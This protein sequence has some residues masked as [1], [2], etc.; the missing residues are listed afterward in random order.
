[1]K[2][3]LLFII[4]INCAFASF[5]GKVS[6]KITDSTGAILAYA[7]IQVKDKNIGT[8]ANSE[9]K[10][11]LSL[12]PG[13]YTIICQHV[14]Y[15]KQEKEIDVTEND[16]TLDFQLVQQQLT[17]SEVIIKKGEDPAYEIIRNAIKKRPVYKD[18]IKNF[19]CEVYTKG[20][21]RLRDYPK[22][23][24][25]SKVEFEDGDTSKKRMLYLS[26][27]ISKYSVQKP[28][29]AK[30]EVVASKVSGQSNSFGLS[31][32][33]IISFYENNIRIGNLSPRGFV[34]PIADGALNF[35]RYKYEGAFFEDGRQISHIKVIPKRKY[36]P[37]F[38]GYINIIEDEWR[39]HSLDLKL[40]KE[41]Q[42]EFVDTLNLQQLYIPIQSNAWVIKSQ[43][44]YPAIK[45]FGFDMHGSFV[46]I[47]SAFDLNPTFAKG[48]FDNTILKYTDSSNK[49]ANDYWETTRPIVLQQDEITDYKKKDSI[50]K[51]HKDPRYLDSLDRR[52][53]SISPVELLLT[54]KTFSKEKKRTY[55]NIPS[56]LNTVNF[57]TAEGWNID[58]SPT[59]FKRLDTLVASRNNISITPTIRYGFS[60][61]H[62]N[63]S[64]AVNYVYGKKYYNRFSVSGGKYVFQFN[65][66]NPIRPFDNTISSLFYNKNYMKVYEAW[67]GSVEYSKG[68]DAGFNGTVGLHYQ[69]RMPLENTSDQQV[70]PKEGMTYTPNYPIELTNHNIARHQVVTASIGLRWQPGTRYIEFPQQKINIGSKYPVFSLSYTQTLKGVLGN[71]LDYG[72]W[73]F[74]ISDN[75]GLR[76]LGRLDYNFRIGGFLWKDS[77]EIPDYKHFSANQL[78][79]TSSSLEGFRLLSSYAASNTAYFFTEGHAEY[80][81][82]GLLTNKIPVFRK[83]NW[84]LV[85]GANAYYI[86]DKNYYVEPFVG[87]ENIFKI[88]RVDFI[89]GY[90]YGQ[91]NLSGIRFGVGGSLFNRR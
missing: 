39:I 87:L 67:F 58:F 69:D 5:A 31:A 35:Y 74:G 78:K 36:E 70:Y 46:N 45:I 48:F 1:M 28:N 19:S 42:M 9:G 44:I 22:K 8:T 37:L 76:L 72:K 81:L 79:V 83:L 14:G 51:A 54:G 41:S 30:V 33:Q 20:Q 12:K 18:E 13:R 34:S 7:S 62:L 6:G 21:L 59:I 25:G 52:R 47:Y 27:T 61:D 60:N 65:N 64:L 23:I 82:N 29:N 71:D 89:Q 91:P 4:L 26:E 10:Y 73:Q 86:G 32:P 38:S 15:Q 16:I 55:T 24:L 43:V 49:K 77:V 80:H 84:Y 11:F 17:L 88:L 56:L 90:R 57:N 63:A 85:T 68:F 53:N 75:V 40:T 66:N 3:I 50:E 2:R